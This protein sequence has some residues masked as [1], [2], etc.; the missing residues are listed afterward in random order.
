MRK[1]AM[2]HGYAIAENS[3]NPFQT[4]LSLILT[5]F[6]PNRNKQAISQ[7]EAANII[8][9]ALISPLKINFD[10]ESYSGHKNAIPIG[11][12][13]SAYNGDDNGKPVI[14]ADAVIWN[15]LYP[16]VKDHIKQAFAEG[17][18]TSWEIYFE[19]SK[20]DDNG[21]QWLEGCIFAGTCIVETPAY[22]PTRTRLLA[23][24]ESLNELSNKGELMPKTESGTEVNQLQTDIY[25]VMDVISGLYN[26]L[27]NMLDQTSE[28]EAQLAT[29]D[30]PAMAEQLTKLLSSIQ[31]TFESLKSK[32]TTA[33]ELKV[34]LESS[35]AEVTTELNTLKDGIA[36][37]EQAA[38]LAEKETKR[39]TAISELG[40]DFDAKKDFYMGM[41]EEMF[42]SYV[43][44]L[45]VVRGSK[46][47]AETRNVI[48]EPTTTPNNVSEMSISD[49]AKAIRDGLKS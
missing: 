33:E 4:K 1:H 29:T 9:S 49:L 43:T 14:K 38:I 6:E 32:A 41:A 30:M 10:G 48:P 21:I 12:I 47:T 27:Y 23:I 5:D 46:A 35:L 17:I 20:T 34:T 28:L 25:A 7:A 16:D 42:E 45:K 26:G 11:A 18:G 15:D 8:N 36:V 37:A 24:A 22:G 19:D 40:L 44:D 2:I 31:S 13:A 39:N 3:S